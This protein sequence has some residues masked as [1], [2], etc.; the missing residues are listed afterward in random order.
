[1]T[2]R[3]DRNR[4]MGILTG[5]A[6]I[7]VVLGHLDMNELS[8]FGLF[9][10]YSFHVCIFIFVS[11]YFYDPEHEKNILAYTA[12]KVIRLLVPYYICNLIYGIISTVLAARGFI[13][14]QPMTFYNL[15]VEPFLGGHQYGLNF[16]AWFVPALFEVEVVNILG[17]RFLTFIRITD[18]HLERIHLNRD[19][20]I[21]VCTLAAGIATVWLAQGGHVWGLYKTPGRILFMLP[22]YELGILYRTRLESY[23]TRIP[24]DICIAALCV[25]QLVIYMISHG[26]LNYSIVWCTSFASYLWVPYATAFTGILL[27]MRVSRMITDS[28]FGRGLDHVGSCSYHIMMHHIAIFWF[29]NLVMYGICQIVP[30]M[31]PFDAAEYLSNVNYTYLPGDMYPWKCVYLAAGVLVPVCIK[32]LYLRFRRGSNRTEPVS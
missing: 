9:P 6:I 8:V 16:A 14:C 7:L 32:S 2:A 11:G 4:T 15:L 22:V 13:Y 3:T 30:G 28:V 29:I 23:E 17:R 10:Y 24:D 21:F 27:W 25:F 31:V 18:D 5:I 1:M 20:I 19:I 26:L 12:H